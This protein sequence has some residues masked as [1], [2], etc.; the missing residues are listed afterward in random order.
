MTVIVPV[1]GA[2]TSTCTTPPWGFRATSATGACASVSSI[3][4]AAPT[5]RMGM[6]ATSNSRLSVKFRKKV[7]WG[8][9]AV[10]DSVTRV[11]RA[12]MPVPGSVPTMDTSDTEEKR[13]SA[14]TPE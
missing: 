2:P 4:V 7:D 12:R 13:P 11:L 1:T 6:A 8:V 10:A 5:V 14:C 9:S 3:N